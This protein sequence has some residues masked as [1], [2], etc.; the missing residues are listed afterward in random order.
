MYTNTN[1]N[2][3]NFFCHNKLYYQ[4]TVEL[5]CILVFLCSDTDEIFLVLS[6]YSYYLKFSYL[7]EGNNEFFIKHDLL[8]IFYR[9]LLY[10]NQ[11][12]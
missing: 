4:Y 10:R 7:M 5:L 3:I 9:V 1:E 12:N 2:L 6:T 11:L 8:L